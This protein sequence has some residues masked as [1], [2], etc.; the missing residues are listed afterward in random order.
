MNF[1]MDVRAVFFGGGG[2]CFVFSPVF[3]E[4]MFPFEALQFYFL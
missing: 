1:V 4:M 3:L 2:E